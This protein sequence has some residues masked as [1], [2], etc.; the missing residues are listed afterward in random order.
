MP[1]DSVLETQAAP[2][3]AL[4]VER[5]LR[6]FQRFVRAE[7]AGGIVLIAC[8][9]IALAWANSPWSASYFALWETHLTIGGTSVG[10]TETLN[11]WI[12]DGLMAA[13]FFL[14]GLEIKRELLIGELAS[15]KQA[16]LP[17]AAAVGGMLVPA[18]IY[19]LINAGGA[20]ARGWG[21]PMATDIAFALG[22]LALLGPRVPPRCA[23]SSR[24]SPSSTTSAPCS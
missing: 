5:A 12:N 14:V 2:A 19:A 1:A 13:F 8:A 22:I 6:P 10:L 9:V 3:E 11:H 23:S 18:A 20:G 24:R 15:A 17:I 21:I 7:A 4:I 16:A